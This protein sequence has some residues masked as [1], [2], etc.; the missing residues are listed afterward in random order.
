MHRLRGLVGAMQRDDLGAGF[1]ARP[2]IAF[3]RARPEVAQ[4][5][6]RV[7]DR[8]T[9]VDG[10]DDPVRLQD[11]DAP[12]IGVD[13]VLGD[14]RRPS[15]LDRGAR[16]QE[17]GIARRHRM[18]DARRRQR[19]RQRRHQPAEQC[20]P[21]PEEMQERLVRHFTLIEIADQVPG[22]CRVEEVRRAPSSYKG[23]KKPDDAGKLVAAAGAEKHVDRLVELGLVERTRPA[24]AAVAVGFA[25]IEMMQ[26]REVGQGVIFRHRRRRLREDRHDAEA[27]VRLAA[28]QAVH[29]R[30]YA[31][32]DIRV[33]PFHDH[34]DVGDWS[35][36][37]CRS[38]HAAPRVR[39]G[40]NAHLRPARLDIK[41]RG[42]GPIRASHA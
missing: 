31:A 1:V 38:S 37:C 17:S 24:P 2:R 19:K 7:V 22:E 27:Q 40:F 34:A 12:L 10:I 23:G 33:G 35:L 25:E 39:I 11:L 36:A 6:A 14:Q 28:D 32:G 42:G 8:E 20:A 15:G 13:A 5:A 16:G 18:V 30:G 41:G 3:E 29:P 9:L 21:R 26:C 4:I